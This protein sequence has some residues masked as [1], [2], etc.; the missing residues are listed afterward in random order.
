MS[1]T[2]IELLLRDPYSIYARHVLRLQP[3]DAVDTPPGARDRG[4]VIHEAIGTFTERYKNALPADPLEEL[5]LLGREGFAKLEDFLMHAPSGGRASSAWRAGSSI[6]SESVAPALT[7]LDAEVGAELEMPIGNEVFKLRTRADR[8]EHLDDGRY[9][10]LD[11]KTGQVPTAP[12]VKTGLSPQLTLEGAILRAG[13][14]EG[15]PQGASIAEYSYVSLRGGEPPGE[16]R[17]YLEGHDAGC[18]GRQGFG[19][20]ES[21]V[22]QICRCRDRLRIARAPN[23]HGPRRRRLRPSRT[24]AGMVA[25]RWR[26]GR[27]GRR[28]MTERVVPEALITKQHDAS[29]PGVS[30]WVSANAGAGKTHVLAQ[31]VVRLLLEGTKPEKSSVSPSPRLQ[32]PIWPTASSRRL[33]AGPRSTMKNSMQKSARPARKRS[34]QTSGKKRGSFLRWRWRRRAV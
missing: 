22:A 20:P 27:G 1:V 32:R 28:R 16:S 5:L 25:I 18:R 24:R 7:K 31:R 11:Y 12:Q 21:G 9:A 26:R 3:L 33:P 10:I 13:C 14:F 30:A 17:D 2:E 4:T 23:V 34:A 19:A 15:I 6:S 29:N 8:I